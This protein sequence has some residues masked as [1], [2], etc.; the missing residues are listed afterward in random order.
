MFNV[1]VGDYNR[2]NHKLL[3]TFETLFILSF[4]MS[5]LLASGTNISLELF[6][7]CS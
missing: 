2:F 1:I 6:S 5:C 4:P 7:E 3:R